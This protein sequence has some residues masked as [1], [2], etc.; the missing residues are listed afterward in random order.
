MS[1]P[2]VV[3]I[4]TREEVIAICKDH[5]AQLE[6]ALRRWEIV[7]RRNELLSE[8]EIEGARKR[9]A[10]LRELLAGD[11]FTDL[12]KQVPDEI[13]YLQADTERRLSKAA[14]KV[15]ASRIYASRLATM[16]QQSLERSAR[17]QHA[18][19]DEL[20]RK[21]Q[22]V[23]QSGGADRKSAERALAEVLASNITSA[24][25]TLT[26]EQ[27]A[28]A[29]RLG[30]GDAARPLEDWLKSSL[31]EADTVAVK[32]AEAIEELSMLA[33]E[34]EAAPFA[35]RHRAIARE[36]PGPRRQMI[37]DTLMLDVG[38]ALART[39]A[40]AEQLRALELKS[41]SLA[42]IKA[43]QAKDLARRIAVAVAERDSASVD[44]FMTQ[45]AA[46]VE[47]ERK[48]VAAKAQRSAIVTALKELGYEVRE[49]METAAPQEGKVIL[50]RAANPE[51]GVEVA[52][53]HG[54]GRVQF[55]PVRFGPSTSAGD[56]R[57]DRDIETIW[58]SDFE[59]LKG[60]IDGEKGT[61][62]VEQ[63]RP[64][65]AVPVLFVDDDL[66]PNDRRPDVRVPIR[67]RSLK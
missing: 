56:N 16:A 3:R 31:P 30:R 20:K 43:P 49:G 53:I 6:V 57:K 29:E 21:L 48:T 23:V 15:V 66:E 40:V 27:R 18:L 17:G 38:K 46:L 12:Q 14:S 62:K 1:G 10:A 64:V 8:G 25:T 65:G 35:Q 58:C 51:M 47:P 5:L 60:R 9:H 39:K 26:P 33:G 59:H 41:V 4:V 52:G 45:V 37:A 44:V 13:A 11:N 55:R 24:A 28:L 36:S 42:S 19:Q 22:E 63:A 7:G 32:A 54:G 61:L 2:K 34:T 50:R 67:T